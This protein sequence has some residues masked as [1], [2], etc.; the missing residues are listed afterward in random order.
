MDRRTEV[1]VAGCRTVGEVEG[2]SWGLHCMKV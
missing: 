1:V 2:R